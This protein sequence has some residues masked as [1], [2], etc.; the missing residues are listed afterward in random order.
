MF[1]FRYGELLSVL[2]EI[3]RQATSRRKHESDIW[4]VGHG[5]GGSYAQLLQL[6]ILAAELYT[7][8]CA[9]FPSGI[10]SEG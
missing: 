6:I 8:S 5:V 4:V 7:V 1:W 3:I 9:Q 10:K 2:P